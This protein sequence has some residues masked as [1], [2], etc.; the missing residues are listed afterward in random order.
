[1]NLIGLILSLSEVY[2]ISPVNITHQ[3]GIDSY[4][5]TFSEAIDQPDPIWAYDTLSETPKLLAFTE[6]P[7]FLPL[8]HTTTTFYANFNLNH[9]FFPILCINTNSTPTFSTTQNSITLSCD[10]SNFDQNSEVFFEEGVFELKDSTDSQILQMLKSQSI[11][12]D[13]SLMIDGVLMVYCPISNPR[14]LFKNSLSA[15]ITTS[16]QSSFITIDASTETSYFNI[17]KIPPNSAFVWTAFNIF[18]K[19]QFN[20]VDDP[21][22]NIPM[23]MEITFTNGTLVVFRILISIL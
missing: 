19:V 21:V 4:T 8:P 11:S 10:F 13:P 12:V 16:S 2:L 5:F 1:M 9:C 22:L 6:N 14:F 3:K 23:L 15:S 17:I 7:I 20:A 18:E